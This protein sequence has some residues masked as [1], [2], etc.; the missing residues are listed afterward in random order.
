MTAIEGQQII[1]YLRQQNRLAELDAIL[2]TRTPQSGPPPLTTNGF[3]EYCLQG[4]EPAESVHEEWDFTPC[5]FLREN[6]CTIY[7]ARP[8][9]CR[10]FVSTV[11]CAETGS[12]EIA[13]LI[14]TINTVF[15][16][17]I[18]HL[19]QGNVWGKMLEILA[20]QQNPSQPEQE[21]SGVSDKK[22]AEAALWRAKATPGLL[23][24]EEEEKPVGAILS[25][26]FSGTIGD[27]QVGRLLGLETGTRG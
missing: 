9:G 10:A 13:P 12:A 4:I 16:Q 17:I 23:V 8:F 22:A 25:T 15:N 14:I 11:N 21:A 24:C 6:I 20:F 3:A 5:P 26:F 2:A 7:P 1:A 27:K 19:D 18:E